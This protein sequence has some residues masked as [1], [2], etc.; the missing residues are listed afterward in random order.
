MKVWWLASSLVAGV[1]A[2][3]S[4]DPHA[5]G[6]CEGYLDLTG[7]PFTGTCEAACQKAGSNGAAPTGMGGTCEA[8]HGSGTSQKFITCGMTFQFDGDLP[9]CCA[10]GTGTA[11]V[12]FFSCR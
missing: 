11:D 1:V 8:V 3:S 6:P 4:P 2:C 12:E 7:Q 10:T 5:V 9:G